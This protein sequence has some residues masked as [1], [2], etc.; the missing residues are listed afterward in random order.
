MINVFRFEKESFI[1]L[2]RMKFHIN[3]SVF[4]YMWSSSVCIKRN[5]MQTNLSLLSVTVVVLPT[6]ILKLIFYSLLADL[7]LNFECCN[8]NIFHYNK[9]DYNQVLAVD[10]ELKINHVG[11]ISFFQWD[12]NQMCK[13]NWFLFCISNISLIHTMIIYICV[14]ITMPSNW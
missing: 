7:V 14:P 11:F 4:L 13:L 1:G 3:F 5:E 9:I 8:R 10:F 6:V 12:L 2:S